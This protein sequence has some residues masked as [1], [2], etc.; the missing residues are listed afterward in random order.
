MVNSPETILGLLVLAFFT[1]VCLLAGLGV[2]AYLLGCLK[3]LTN[4]LP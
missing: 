2:G 1:P 4:K 3:R